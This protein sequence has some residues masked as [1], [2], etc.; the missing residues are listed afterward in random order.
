MV[1]SV[2]YERE[3]NRE[4]SK[5]AYCSVILQCTFW[6]RIEHSN[7]M[8]PAHAC[9]TVY[10]EQCSHARSLSNISHKSLEHELHSGW[11]AVLQDD[12]LGQV[13]EVACADCD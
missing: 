8:E 9:W 10:D 11:P 6:D 1:Y 5:N 2:Q 4:K 13:R 3:E 12:S 7:I